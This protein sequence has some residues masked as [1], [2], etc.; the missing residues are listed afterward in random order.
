MIGERER[1]GIQETVEGGEHKH[2]H[3]HTH[4]KKHTLFC[5]NGTSTGMA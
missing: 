1:E 2:T 4:K 5:M 3:I